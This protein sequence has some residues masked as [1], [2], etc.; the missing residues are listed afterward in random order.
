MLV[1][2][3][4]FMCHLCYSLCLPSMW[5][6]PKCLLSILFSSYLNVVFNTFR[7][8]TCYDLAIVSDIS[9]IFLLKLIWNSSC[10]A[11]Y[12][13][14]V[15][16]SLLSPKNQWMTVTEWLSYLCWDSMYEA[17]HYLSLFW[18]HFPMVICVVSTI[19]IT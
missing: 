18:L 11:L 7:I 15:H 9:L 8:H 13:W 10:D 12:W 1:D 17:L 19:C 16:V 2:L 14:I 5:L 6:S 4:R 3:Q